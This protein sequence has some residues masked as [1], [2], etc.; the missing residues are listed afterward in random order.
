VLPP[1][2]VTNAQGVATFSDL[3]IT[4]SDLF[5]L[6]FTTPDVASATSSLISVGAM[7]GGTSSTNSIDPTQLTISTQPSSSAPSGSVLAQQPSI[8][9]RDAANNLVSQAGVVVT[10]AIAS[11]GGA[12][13]GNP[14]ATTN[15]AGVATFSNLS[16][17]GAAGPRTL[18]FASSGLASTTSSAITIGAGAATKLAI[19][20]QPSGSATSGTTFARQPAVQ[21]RDAASNTVKQ[22]GVIVTATIASGESGVL[23]GGITATT[24]GSGVASFS[25]LQITGSGSYALAFSAPSVTGVGSSAITVSAAGTGSAAGAATATKL[26]VIAQPSTEASGAVFT[27]QPV[28]QLRDGSNSPVTVAGVAVTASIANGGGTLGGTTVV[29]TNAGG[30]ASFKNLSITGMVGSRTLNFSSG[31]LQAATSTVNIAAGTASKLVVSTIVQQTAGTAFDVTVTLTDAS[32][33]PVTNAGASGTVT[34]T[35]Q[36]G[37]G[38]VAG[39]TSGTIPVGMSAVVISGVTYSVAESGVALLATGTGANSSVAGRT[40]VSNAFVTA[41]ASSPASPS[42][43]SSPSDPSDPSGSS[44]STAVVEDFSAYSSTSNLLANPRGIWAT[45]EAKNTDH[46]VLDQSVGYGASTQSMRYDWPN[47]GAQCLDYAIKP[48]MLKIPGNLKHVWIEFVVRFSKNFSVN[49]GASGCASEYKLASLGDYSHGVGRWDIAE[50]QANQ[51]NAD[52]P[53]G[54][55]TVVTTPKP[56]TLWDGQPH[57][58]RV[59]AQLGQGNGALRMWI[60]GQLVVN[61]TGLTTTASHQVIDI[62]GPGLNINQGPGVSGM[63]MWWHKIAVYSSNPGWN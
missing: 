34:L 2:A 15:A 30:I 51:F 11:G 23:G 48:G 50:M 52:A 10:A 7:T 57:V 29:T 19:I 55:F 3:S 36:A 53:G 14:T 17:S 56:S 35:R 60:D 58:F 54:P 37:T 45:T 39:T 61:Q 42:A 21:L 38:T 28:I 18:T 20:T 59:D 27:Q 12:L 41:A 25:N 32:N 43:P 47:N 13:G 4:G 22:A 24:D 8:Q 5:T 6:A 33:N 9:L 44:G 16:I 40:G 63:Q 46:I 49:A 1:S 31:S 26:S 62:F